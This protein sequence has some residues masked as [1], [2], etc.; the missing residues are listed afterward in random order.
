MNSAGRV[1]RIIDTLVERRS[2]LDP[3]TSMLH[4]WASVFDIELPQSSNVGSLLENDVVACLL[5]FRS[6]I[7]LVVTKFREQGAPDELFEPAVSSLMK[8]SS[9]G[10]LQHPWSNYFSEAIK[11][12]NRI[13]FAW[14]TWLLR[15]ESED[16]IADADFIAFLNELEAL[17]ASLDEVEMSAP[18]RRFVIKQIDVIRSALRIYRVRGLEPVQSA[19]RQA[20][21]SCIAERAKLEREIEVATPEAKSRLKRFA[22]I[23]DKTGKICDSLDKVQKLGSSVGP[24]LES[25]IKA[26]TQ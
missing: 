23:I 15:E 26:L 2:T 12:E 20:A 22:D 13:P 25:A 17:Q 8:L 19:F 18:L 5:A 21:G 14:A 16:E 3:N 9:S 24:L 1:G 11:I 10:L 6:E 4:V 7:D